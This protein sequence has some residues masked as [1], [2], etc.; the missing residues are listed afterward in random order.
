MQFPALIF[1]MDSVSLPYVTE[2][3]RHCT[4]YGKVQ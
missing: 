3:Y 1:E 4:T 2:V